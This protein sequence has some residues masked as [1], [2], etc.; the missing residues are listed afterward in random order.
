VTSAFIN[1]VAVDDLPPE[2]PTRAEGDVLQALRSLPEGT[3]G[4]VGVSP[5]DVTAAL[6]KCGPSTAT[7]GSVR[8]H[9]EALEKK[10]LVVKVGRGRWLQTDYKVFHSTYYEEIEGSESDLEQPE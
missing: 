10:R 9:L 7:D 2:R 1:F 8:K 3:A 4:G 6:R 5:A